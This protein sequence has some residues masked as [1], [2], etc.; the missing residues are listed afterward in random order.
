[1]S[2]IFRPGDYN[3]G[4]EFGKEVRQG[5]DTILQRKQK[6]EAITRRKEAFKQGNLPEWLA[7]LPDNMQ[8]TLL[9]EYQFLPE[10]EKQQVQ[11]QL[12]DMTKQY[13]T[14]WNQPD[15]QDMRSTLMGLKQA[16]PQGGDLVNMDVFNQK[17]RLDI[18]ERTIPGTNTLD[19]AGDSFAPGPRGYDNA[20]QQ[21]IPRE[22]TGNQGAPSPSAT[23]VA[24]GP[25]KYRMVPRGT[26]GQSTQSEKLRE[27]EYKEQA[28]LRPVVEA[29]VKDIRAQRNSR[30]IA[31]EALDN[32]VKNEKKWP[33]MFRGLATKA[34]GD[35][36]V[37]DPDVR[38]Y[39]ADISKLVMA[40]AGT[41]RG[42]PTNYKVK[43]EQ[44]AKSDLSMPYETQK[45]L[46]ESII[47]KGDEAELRLRFI[48]E[49]KNEQGQYPTDLSTRIAEFD[50]ALDNPLEYPQYYKKN[51]TYEDDNGIAYIHD[52]YGWRAE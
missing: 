40:E 24:E 16:S 47:N 26:S 39:V 1:M 45:K 25:K 7:E 50:M 15:E 38:K 22:G 36:A 49:V 6:E 31:K 2:V 4:N 34:L 43:L 12:N 5:L 52:G 37:Q 21:M 30:K 29:E 46:L 35:W 41:R 28:A 42:Q 11:Q 8:T 27:R 3:F 13:W 23:G 20:A 17:Q 14:D 32:L 18:P 44:L 10:Q 9:K 51:D 19:Q 48:N 33:G